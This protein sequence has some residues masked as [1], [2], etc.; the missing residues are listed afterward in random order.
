[1]ETDGSKT[2]PGILSPR[3]VYLADEHRDHVQLA[4]GSMPSAVIEPRVLLGAARTLLAQV[5]LNAETVL[6]AQD[7]HAIEQAIALAM[8][9]L[10]SGR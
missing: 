1:M 6:R 10:K 3:L 8:L 2:L 4:V 5:P 9:A 7:I